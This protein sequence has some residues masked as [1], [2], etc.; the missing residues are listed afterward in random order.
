MAKNF[1]IRCF[2]RRQAEGGGREE[3]GLVLHWRGRA[4]RARAR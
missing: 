4:A 1:G 3:D 2:W